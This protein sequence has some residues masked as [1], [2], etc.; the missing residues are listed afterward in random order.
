MQASTATGS[1]HFPRFSGVAVVLCGKRRYPLTRV[2]QT[3]VESCDLSHRVLR[4]VLIWAGVSGK[5]ERKKRH[6]RGDGIAY[7]FARAR[8]SSAISALDRSTRSLSGGI[9]APPQMIG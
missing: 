8:A 6:K 4:S 5:G 7:H 2:T 9:Y 3:H 1:R